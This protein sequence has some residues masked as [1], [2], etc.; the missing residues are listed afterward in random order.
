MNNE[1]W[2]PY[3]YLSEHVLFTDLKNGYAIHNTFSS[4]DVSVY[5][6]SN[7]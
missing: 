2:G 3:K 6:L 7:R 4:F 5:S 1:D